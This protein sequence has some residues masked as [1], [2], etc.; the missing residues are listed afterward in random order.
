[1][2]RLTLILLIILISQNIYAA[3]ISNIIIDNKENYSQIKF[4]FKEEIPQFSISQ[5][6]Q[7]VKI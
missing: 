2:F 4:L 6:E 3:E 5:R 1:M 7:K